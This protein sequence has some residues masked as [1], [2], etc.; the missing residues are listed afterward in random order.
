GSDSRV[1]MLARLALVT[2]VPVVAL[3]AAVCL[4]GTASGARGTP[5]AAST[6]MADAKTTAQ[7]IRQ[8]DRQLE[9]LVV[10]VSRMSAEGAD[11][12]KHWQ[13]AG[14][15]GEKI[16]MWALTA[17]RYD[18]TRTVYDRLILMVPVGATDF[19]RGTITLEF[20]SL[21]KDPD[22]TLLKNAPNAWET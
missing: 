1:A 19:L 17:P 22:K 18:G 8:T 15:H 12:V 11:N 14:K 6:A 5:L 2:L 4:A 20:G 9:S 10:R 3:A 13:I 7:M 16:V 21:R